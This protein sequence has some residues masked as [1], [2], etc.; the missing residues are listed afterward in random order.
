MGRNKQV[1]TMNDDLKLQERPPVTIGNMQK[2]GVV[3]LQGPHRE[4]K[5]SRPLPG[6]RY[7]IHAGEE[8]QIPAAVWDRYKDRADVKALLGTKLMEGGL[9]KATPDSFGHNA[10]VDSYVASQMRKLEEERA[11]YD[12][13]MNQRMAELKAAQN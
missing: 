10:D 9:A 12:E 1:N 2:I 13:Y 7:E 4:V 5:G 11:R 8:A 3:Y 6:E